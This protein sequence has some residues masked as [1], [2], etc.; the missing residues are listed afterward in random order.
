MGTRG[1]MIA[2]CLL[3]G[4]IGSADAASG[5]AAGKRQTRPTAANETAPAKAQDMIAEMLAGRRKNA[6]IPPLT[7][8]HGSFSLDEAYTIQRLLARR[9]RWR[10]GPVAGYKVAY[11]SKAAQEQFGIQAPAS[12][13]LFQIQ[14]VPAG[15]ILRSEEFTELLIETEVAFTIGR[16][17]R[18]PIKD[19]D[20]L[21]PY[22][23][24]V[25]AAFD[26]GNDRYDSAP[27]RPVVADQ[28][29]NGVG[30][31]RFVLGPA[32]DPDEVDV[33]A[34]ILKLAVNG[35]SVAESAATNVMGSPWNSLLWLANQVVERGDVLEP[36]HVVLTGTA[37]PAYKAK[38][39]DLAGSYLGDCGLL[40]KVSCT[41]R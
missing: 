20:S 41:I 3:L 26:I 8:T 36:G 11:A 27:A 2:Y 38:G 40:G 6:P 21:K 17:V 16:R 25:H 19:V 14:R 22:V 1:L 30:A 33:D 15:S 5:G 13:P 31:H 10:L 32:M 7:H 34:A 18:E 4:A 23:R 39:A 28:V 9:L 37:A 12:G 35:K 29:A 24:W